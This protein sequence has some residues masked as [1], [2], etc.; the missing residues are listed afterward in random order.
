MAVTGQ[1]FSQAIASPARAASRSSRSTAG[2]LGLSRSLM[3]TPAHSSEGNT[4]GAAFQSEVCAKA[5][6]QPSQPGILSRP[7]NSS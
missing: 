1:I 2:S 4:P 5:P 7:I 3:A 6:F